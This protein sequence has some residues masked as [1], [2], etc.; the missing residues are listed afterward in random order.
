MK[1]KVN[2]L[3]MSSLSLIGMT[4]HGGIPPV[5]TF[6]KSDYGTISGRLQNV[7]MYR[8]FADDGARTAKGSNVGIVL[9]YLS[10]KSEGLDFGLTYT[11]AWE[12]WDE[13]NSPLLSLGNVNVLNEAWLRYGFTD[14]A[15][16]TLGRKVHHGQVF[17]KDDYRQKE[18]SLEGIRFDYAG[19]DTSLVLGHAWRLANWKGRDDHREDFQNFKDVFKYQGYEPPEDTDGVTWG[20]WTYTGLDNLKFI[21]YDGYAHDVANLFG[22]RAEYN[23]SD[24]TKLQGVFRSEAEVGDSTAGDAQTYDL[25]IS[26]K[27]GK[28]KVIAGYFGVRGSD[29]VFGEES[30]GNPTPLGY[31]AGQYKEGANSPYFRYIT[32]I[33]KTFVFLMADL[34][35]HD[36][37]PFDGQYYGA[38]IKHP[39]TDKFS[40]TFKGWVG[41]RDYKDGH[42]NA[43]GTDESTSYDW[44]LFLT[45]KF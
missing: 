19:D 8:D 22:V 24:A 2:I 39:I 30:T 16:V 14:K 41:F 25:S 7:T 18:R 38:V 37:Q 12:F 23:F 10:P 17:T 15:S 43:T 35:F 21:I 1:V 31:Y 26:H 28:S 27:F 40:A 36:V 11:G 4:A 34:P 3:L 5:D 33:G 44:R 20:E 45:Y 29:V 42:T 9:K 6:N 13:G 32:T